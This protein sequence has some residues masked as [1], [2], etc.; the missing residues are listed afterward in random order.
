MNGIMGTT[1]VLLKMN[2]SEKEMEIIRIIKNSGAVLMNLI[3]DVL[4]FSKIEAGRLML[5]EIPFNLNDEVRLTVELF[6]SMIVDKG[7]KFNYFIK[8]D[9]PVQLIGDPFRLRQVLSNLLSNAIKFTEKGEII[10]G[11]EFVERYN[12][13][14]TL[15]FYVEDTGIGIPRE[16]QASIFA[17]YEQGGVKT[18]RKYGGSGLGISIAR[19]IVEMMNGEIWVE[20]PTALS[21]NKDYPGTKFSFTIE[22]YSNEKLNKKFDFSGITRFQEVSTLII[23]RQ[24]DESDTI[25][26][27]LDQLGINYNIIT[28]DGESL[29]DT[30]HHIEQNRNVYQ[31]IIILDKPQNDGF[32]IAQKIKED[33]LSEYFPVIIIS[34]DDKRGNYLKARNNGAD[35]YL[36]FPFES[37]EIYSIL[38]DI[39]PGI[40]EFLVLSNMVNK[41]RPG[42]NILVAEDNILNQRINQNVFKHLGYEVTIVSN[43]TEILE[44]MK[45]RKFDIIFMDLVMPVM[46]GIATIGEI[47][48][49]DKKI[50]VIAI[51]GV[52]EEYRKKEALAAG[53]NELIVKPLKVDTVKQILIKWFS[54]T[55]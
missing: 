34:S 1:D 53:I 48:K 13:V 40:K 14:L 9:V 36:I 25:H 43:G 32:T 46:D 22:L 29:D 44:H 12:N 38:K 3:N 27:F 31:L 8:P 54:E 20:S 15:L 26:H 37:N 21:R 45:S 49:K 33:G 50:P 47:R 19:Q 17:D 16:N 41:I 2:F 51:T 6:R 7:L 24:R 30:I 18:A 39:F 10:I 35:Y 11:V 28:I 23:T 55:I 42:L 52:D 5:E 4:D